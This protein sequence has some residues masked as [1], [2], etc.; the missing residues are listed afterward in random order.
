VNGS[1]PMRSAQKTQRSRNTIGS[2]LLFAFALFGFP[3]VGV[4]ISLFQIDSRLL[5]IPFRVAVA[6]YSLWIMANS[7]RLRVDGL[8]QV[9][10][11]IW[12]FYILRLLHDWFFTSLQGADY[13]LQ[14][15][16]AC[17]VLPA[18]GLMKANNYDQRRFATAGFA[19]A[20]VGSIMSLLAT[21]FGSVEAQNLSDSTGR[22]SLTALNSVTLGHLAVSGIICG[23]AIW[24][25]AKLWSRLVMMGVMPVLVV[26]LVQSGSKGPALTLA[27]CVGFLALRQGKLVRFLL[28]AA[29]FFFF[30]IVA[31]DSNPLA[32]RIA[33]Y[34]EDQSTVDRIVIL[35]DSIVQ[36]QSAPFMG[37][38][39]VELNSEFYPHNVFVEAPMALGIPLGAVFAGLILFGALR[40]WKEL[41]GRNYFL[42]LLYFQGVLAATVSGSLFGSTLLW[43]VLAILPRNV[44][45][46]TRARESDSN[47]LELAG[48]RAFQ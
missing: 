22:L 47:V 32:S 21:R 20:S 45:K 1:D 27:I 26:C 2:S 33:G 17:S 38:A 5:S 18:V 11:A 24:P 10:L 9:M 15:F 43:I 19:V 29:P 7:R 46:V 36:I 3:L 4:I 30:L 44:R 40:A 13:A 8:R 16:I 42:G 25:R 48:P 41:K 35:N 37:S 23:L 34:E 39:F 14:F 6:L 31:S 28:L 12:F